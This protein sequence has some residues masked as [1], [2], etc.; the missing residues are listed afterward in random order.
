MN[1]LSL[2]ICLISGAVGGSVVGAVMKNSSL[3]TV[4]NSLIGILGGGAG[5]AILPELG[6]SAGTAGDLGS[7]LV[8]VAGGGL[9]GTVL[10]AMV[11]LLKTAFATKD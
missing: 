4:G 3:G 8:N 2:V 9:G 5:A 7:M 11:G 10:V 6:V 1:I